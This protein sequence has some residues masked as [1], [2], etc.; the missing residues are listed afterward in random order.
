MERHPTVGIIA[1]A[2]NGTKIVM[3]ALDESIID[4]GTP[5][6]FGG[7]VSEIILEADGKKLPSASPKSTRIA[8]M[9][10]NDQ[11]IP[12]RTVN[13]DQENTMI[14]N[15]FLEPNRS[16]NQPPGICINA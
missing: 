2:K 6:C 13:K 9:D 15:T 4:M 3:N 16:A 12:V 11:A 14:S 7:N 5:R 8:I 1:L 10:I